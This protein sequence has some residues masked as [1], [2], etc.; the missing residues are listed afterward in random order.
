MALITTQLNS[1]AYIIVEQQINLIS[2]QKPFSHEESLV[3]LLLW[4]HTALGLYT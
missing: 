2:L 3:R 4:H 1:A